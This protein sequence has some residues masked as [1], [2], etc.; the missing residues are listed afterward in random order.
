LLVTLQGKGGAQVGVEA[1][2]RFLDF[3]SVSMATDGTAWARV[4]DE[5]VCGSGSDSV[6]RWEGQRW[7]EVPSPDDALSGL[8]MSAL[9]RDHAF[10]VNVFGENLM[11]VR[12]GEWRARGGLSNGWSAWAASAED[13]WVGGSSDELFRWRGGA[14][15]TL[16]PKGKGRQV[17]EVRA[18]GDVAWMVAKGYTRDDTDAHV[19]RYEAGVRREWNL[20][21]SRERVTLSALDAEHVWHSGSPAKAWRA[22]DWQQLPFNASGVWARTPNEVYFTRGGDIFRWNGTELVRVYRGFIHIR[23]FAGRGDR[24]IA[25]G[26]GGLTIEF[27]AEPA[28]GR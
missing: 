23:H 20:G 1:V 4:T 26:R 15:T 12:N 7:A 8:S 25:V 24:A 28:S 11:E 16:L 18:T 14:V 9:A 13:V 3:E 21:L 10:T 5:T 27:T 2:D 6:A 19:Y 17:Q 22:T